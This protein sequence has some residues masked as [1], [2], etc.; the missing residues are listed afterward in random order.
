MPEFCGEFAPF[1]FVFVGDAFL[2]RRSV[3]FLGPLEA[4]D[5]HFA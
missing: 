3:G 1:L 4:G 2:R 5:E